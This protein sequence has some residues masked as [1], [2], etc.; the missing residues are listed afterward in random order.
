MNRL[1]MNQPSFFARRTFGA[2]NYFL[3]ALAM[4][5]LL[6]MVPRGTR[7]AIESNT[8]NVKDWLPRSY[9]ESADVRWFQRHFVGE[10]FAV[11]TYD[12][13]TLGSHEALT[14]LAKKLVPAQQ[15]TIQSDAPAA[16]GAREITPVVATPPRIERSDDAKKWFTRVITG[17][18]MLDE[19]TGGAQ[20]F[21]RSEALDRLEGALFGPRKT[22]AK[23]ELLPQESRTT[24]LVVTLSRHAVANNK[25]MRAAIETIEDVAVNQCAIPLSSLRMGGPPV[26]NVTI[27]VEGE[28]TLFRLAILSGIVGL[29]LAYWCFRSFKLTAMV[30]AVGVASAG[31]S[32]ALVFYFGIYE[33][34]VLGRV[35]FGTVDAI[36]MSMPPVVYVL[37]ISGAIHIIN[38]YK[39]ARREE[40]L[41]GAAEKAL[42]HGWGPCTLAALTT[43]VGLG[44]LYTSDIIPIKKFGTFTAVAVLGT[45]GILFT[46]LPVALHRFPLNQREI[47]IGEKK[48]RRHGTGGFS[49]A[50]ALERIGGFVVRHNVAVCCFWLALMGFFAI[51]LTR[52]QTSVQLLKLFDE[53]ADIIHD[54]AWLEENLGNLVPMEVVVAIDKEQTRIGELD[55]SAEAN[56][57]RYRMT[58]VERVQLIDK[59]VRRIESL[60][61]VG[62]AMALSTFVPELQS[63]SFLDA[64]NRA[65]L[66]KELGEEIAESNDYVT[67]E[68]MT[69]NQLDDLN[70]EGLTGRELWRVSARVRALA[71]EGRAEIDY[72]RFVKTLRGAVEPVMLSYRQRDQVLAALHKEDKSLAGSRLLMLYRASPG[73]EKPAPQ[74]QEA[75]LAE[76]LL[77][78]HASVGGYF[79]L[80]N[81]REW[82]EEKIQKFKEVLGGGYDALVI[83]SVGRDPAARDLAAGAVPLIDVSEDP[84]PGGTPTKWD[85]ASVEPLPVGAVYTGIVPL[86]Y[87]TQRQLLVSLRESIGWATVL[88]AI[89]MVVVLRSPAAGIA[90]MIPNIFPIIIVFG[91]LGWL[92]IKVDIGI[93]MTASVALGVA[94]DDTIHFVWW[95]QH[96]ISEGM[97][98]KS[99]VAYAYDRCGTAMTQT[100]IIAGLGLA[101]FAASTFTPTQQFGILM[102]TMLSAALVGDL[103]LLPA[104]LAGPVGSFFS[105]RVARRAARQLTQEESEAR[106]YT[107]HSVRRRHDPAHRSARAS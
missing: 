59:I 104:L 28:K 18:G 71:D 25:N 19:L 33:N 92:G 100:T 99:A 61:E 21:S 98:R 102:I 93:M 11:V 83:A 35:R 29:T 65:A 77:E 39:D 81:L 42:S 76:L 24:C 58:Y 55:E 86:V 63:G 3:I 73:A 69:A 13:C 16:D 31:M 34:L 9:P 41:T 91:A 15:R 66:E 2:P 50:S 88:I 74:S 62:K 78:S 101:V 5:F 23:G 90:A 8:N 26:D 106:I 54:Y 12:G 72:G 68:R 49:I 30:F 60:P 7:Q 47:R 27:D 105:R 44:S 10:Q 107:P 48:L 6:A 40:G 4:A 37:G 52:I 43:A 96:G 79:N 70:A 22:D 89:V 94:V 36:L 85:V 51:G 84:A 75:L 57:E 53:D 17:P 1:M 87:K 56:G 38:Y 95:F 32:L 45:L 64:G 67:D 20:A 14:L 103:L 97:D 82:N 80:A 46:V